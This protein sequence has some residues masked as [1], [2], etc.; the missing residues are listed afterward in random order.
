MTEKAV[1]WETFEWRC[2][3]DLCRF[4]IGQGGMLGTLQGVGG[5]TMT[6]PMVAWEGLL[7]SLRVTRKSR[8]RSAAPLPSRFGARW[9]QTESEELKASFSA[10]KSVPA[11]AAMHGRTRAAIQS[12][13]ARQGLIMA[14]YKSG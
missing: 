8:E 13:L 14:P 11:L 1:A 12:E 6:L 4:E 7:D 3:A 9:S 5:Q 10:G 2:G